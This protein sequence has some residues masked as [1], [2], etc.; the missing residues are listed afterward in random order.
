MIPH[1]DIVVAE[2]N[3]KEYFTAV[4]EDVGILDSNWVG[5]L[6]YVSI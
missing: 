2:H 3:K 5:Y 1:G 6:P 4:A